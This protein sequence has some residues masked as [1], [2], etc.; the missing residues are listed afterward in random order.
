MSIINQQRRQ[1][2]VTREDVQKLIAQDLG[3]DPARVNVSYDVA[4]TERTSPYCGATAFVNELLVYV[5]P[6]ADE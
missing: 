4:V 2:V 1:I 5:F 3:I 6:A